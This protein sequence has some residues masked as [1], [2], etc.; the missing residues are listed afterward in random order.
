MALLDHALSH[1]RQNIT[2]GN[3]NVI[4]RVKARSVDQKK[5]GDAKQVQ[6]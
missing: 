4:A 5:K 6:S 1:K 2:R 3:L